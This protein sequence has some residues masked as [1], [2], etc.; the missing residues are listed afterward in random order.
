PQGEEGSGRSDRSI[1]QGEEGSGRSDRS[2]PQGEEGSDR[3]DRSSPLGGRGL[4]PL[5]PLFPPGGKRAPSVPTALPP[6]GMLR[7]CRRLSPSLEHGKRE[8]L[9][10]LHHQG[11]V[12]GDEGEGEAAYSF[13]ELVAERAAAWMEERPE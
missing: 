1:P 10:E 11:L 6:Y 9:G 12:G 3:S 4:R 5:R 7:R 2:I 13:H 8:L